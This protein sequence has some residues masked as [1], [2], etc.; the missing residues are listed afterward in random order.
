MYF[1]KIKFIFRNE[2]FPVFPLP[3]VKKIHSHKLLWYFCHSSSQLR[4]F[5]IFFFWRQTPGILRIK[6]YVEAWILKFN[7]IYSINSICD[8][9]ISD[10]LMAACKTWVRELPRDLKFSFQQYH[11][12]LAQW[13]F[14]KPFCF[15]SELSVSNKFQLFH[16]F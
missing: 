14:C 16:C 4:L 10:G 1:L 3:A 6:L 13:P 2:A 12:H 5:T 8:I 15:Y 7:S 11:H 9:C